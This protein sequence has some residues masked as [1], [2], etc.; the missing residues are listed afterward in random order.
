M[1]MTKWLSTIFFLCNLFGIVAILMAALN[2]YSDF[3][4]AHIYFFL[5]PLWI[6]VIGSFLL[7]KYESW[8]NEREM[9]QMG[10]SR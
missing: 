7:P 9:R 6:G 3:I 5:V 1:M 4:Q 8:K 10:G 2:I